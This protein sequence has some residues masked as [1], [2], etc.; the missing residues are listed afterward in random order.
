[1]STKT[2][3][4]S[5]K[6]PGAWQWL[7]VASSGADMVIA[8]VARNNDGLVVEG[9]WRSCVS[10]D[11]EETP[12]SRFSLLKDILGSKI[13]RQLPSCVVLDEQSYDVLT[14]EEPDLKD[15]SE[16]Q[17]RQALQ[18]AIAPL[19][20]FP[21]DRASM[22]VLIT[23]SAGRRQVMVAIAK[24]QVIAP[25]MQ[26]CVDE[27]VNLRAIDVPE[28]AQRNLAHLFEES[29]G[30]IGLLS[31]SGSRAMLTLSAN[32]ELLM[33]RR[34]ETGLVDSIVTDAKLRDRIG[35]EIYRTLDNFERQSGRSSSTQL[36]L[37]PGPH[38][39]V[40][41][42]H[43]REELRLSVHVIDA[44]LLDQAFKVSEKVTINPSQWGHL[45]LLAIGTAC[46]GES[47]R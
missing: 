43:L 45:E 25:W 44:R 41:M 24:E 14:L 32:G 26:A 31:F 21:V 7:G 30:A 38:A 20:S 18:W 35:L 40:L 12:A 13:A 16:A 3:A 2:V 47:A 9:L 37:T 15:V 1:M 6:F 42:Q 23:S 4:S 46:R 27:R 34:I 29:S 10:A 17:R 39:Q 22:D 33:T 11:A 36:I 19:V 28:M 5:V 8:H